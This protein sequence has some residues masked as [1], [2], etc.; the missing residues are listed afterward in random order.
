MNVRCVCERAAP[1]ASTY[2]RK[3]FTRF[4][5]E[6]NMRAR[7][8]SGI[9]ADS[10][11]LI[12][13]CSIFIFIFPIDL[14]IT[15]LPLVTKDLPISPRFKPYEFLSD[16]SS[17]ILQLVNQ[18]LNFT[19]LVLMFPRFPLRKREHKSYFGKNRTHDFRTSGCASYL[20]D[21]SG[22][23]RTS[24]TSFDERIRLRLTRI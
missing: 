10:I 19:Y 22:V 1:S 20:L 9:G 17:A 21:H 15:I 4:A 12:V 14:I 16:A 5:R 3:C 8:L 7:P 13:Q 6:F 11:L 18:W 2:T 24:S 23:S